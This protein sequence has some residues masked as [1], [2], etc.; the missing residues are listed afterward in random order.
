MGIRIRID[1]VYLQYQATKRTNR[2]ELD[3]DALG[4]VARSNAGIVNLTEE[5]HGE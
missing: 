1:E 2:S 5:T 4:R 3:R